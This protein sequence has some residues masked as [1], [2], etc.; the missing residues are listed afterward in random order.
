LG[1]ESVKPAHSVPL[2]AQNPADT[3]AF[4]MSSVVGVLVTQDVIAKAEKLKVYLR[5]CN[6]L[7]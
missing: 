6:V 5:P 1:E 2:L 4:K 7:L 3:T